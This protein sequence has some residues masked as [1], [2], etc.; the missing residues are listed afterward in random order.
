MSKMSL[1][2]VSFIAVVP[3]L[4]LCYLLAMAFIGHLDTLLTSTPLVIVAGL[5]LL[6]AALMVVMPAGILVFG[7]KSA[8]AKK[9]AEEV[10]EEAEPVA[11]A[12]PVEVQ[13]GAGSVLDEDDPV[14][15][16]QRQE[17]VEEVEVRE[18]QPDVFA[19]GQEDEDPFAEFY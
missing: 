17:V 10:D 12:G 2:G 11:E 18:E 19:E 5:T 4:A 13:A 16:E 15:V 9:D 3:G 1:I 7:P 6:A 14:V 8:T